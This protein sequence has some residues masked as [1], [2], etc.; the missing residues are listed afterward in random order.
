MPPKTGRRRRPRASF[1]AC[2]SS[3]TAV[4]A[5]YEK[6]E[7]ASFSNHADWVDAIAPGVSI[8]SSY[9]GGAYTT[10]KGTS[11]ASPHVSGCFAL[12]KQKYP[13]ASVTTIE[14]A[15]EESATVS[16]SRDGIAKPRIDCY[17]AVLGPGATTPISPQGTTSDTTPTYS[18]RAV[19]A[20]ESY[21]LQVHSGSGEV[22][23]AS[24]TAAQ[25]GCGEGT[26]TCSVTPSAALQSVA[27]NW[28]IQTRN[29]YGSGSW[30]ARTSFTVRAGGGS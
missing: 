13:S 15:L 29:P 24:Y 27:H 7:L 19:A 8:Q 9:T 3:A 28:R 10:F 18:W 12:Y 25:A 21:D 16:I 14:E 5:S 11:L 30:S 17:A 20:A 2:I 23:R 1:P 22:H 26:G 4:G 6:G